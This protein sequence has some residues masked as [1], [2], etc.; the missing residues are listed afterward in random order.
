MRREAAYVEGV[1]EIQDKLQVAEGEGRTMRAELEETRK[2]LRSTSATVI[3]LDNAL[4]ARS[5]DLDA[6]VNESRQ[7]QDRWGVC[8]QAAVKQSSK[9]RAF[10]RWARDAQRSKVNMQIIHTAFAST[11]R[12]W[13]RR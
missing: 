7:C 10:M 2:N 9:S 11:S 1:Q 3:S 12:C 13:F 4:A 6:A 8:S 5:K